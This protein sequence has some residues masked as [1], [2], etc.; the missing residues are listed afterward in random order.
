MPD[1]E[2]TAVAS[3]LLPQ[4]WICLVAMVVAVFFMQFSL[5]I[6]P[7]VATTIMPEMGMTPAQFGMLANMPYLC[8]VLFGVI[9]GNVG[10]RVGIKKIM[11]IAIVAFII[12]AFWR[13]QSIGSFAMMM[14]SSLVMGFGLAVLNANSTKGIRLWFPGKALGPAMGLYIAGASLGAGAALYAGPMLGTSPALLVSACS[15]VVTFIIWIALYRTHPAEDSQASG[16]AKG[17]F[18]VVMKN[19]DVWIVSLMIMFVFGNSTTFQTYMVAGLNSCAAAGGIDGTQTV[20]LI[21]AV[22]TVFVAL[23]SIISPV[24]VRKFKSLRMG[25]LVVCII[26]GICTVLMLMVPF[27]ALTWVVMIIAG[28][29]LGAM[30]A[31]GKTVPALIPDIDPRNLGAVGGL[32]STL[33]NLGGWIIA[34]YI[35]APIA[36]AAVPAVSVTEAGAVYGLGT[37]QAIY[38]GAMICSLL[39]AICYIALNKKVSFANAAAADE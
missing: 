15:A 11:T 39:V 25:M 35:I 19:K 8:G 5:I 6:I 33:Q 31:M 12:G 28:L 13:W 37:Y 18:G 38:V 29:G 7:G 26:E 24:F 16:V 2:N 27:G 36:Q 23:A 17:A 20:A 32:Q 14:V 9:M 34:G 1:N 4:R 3:Q 10:D 21:S 22:S 30:L